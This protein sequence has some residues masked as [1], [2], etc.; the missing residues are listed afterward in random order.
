MGGC[1]RTWSLQSGSIGWENRRAD[2]AQG[3]EQGPTAR[4][5]ALRCCWPMRQA[6]GKGPAWALNKGPSSTKRYAL[7][8]VDP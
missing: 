3:P 2:E 8:A 5:M 7:A 1:S 6:L 4:P